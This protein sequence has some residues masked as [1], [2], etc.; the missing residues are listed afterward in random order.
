MTSGKG[1]LSPKPVS[2][3]ARSAL[4]TPKHGGILPYQPAPVWM[5]VA[6]PLQA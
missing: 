3:L 5:G 6:D 1:V 2:V 4:L